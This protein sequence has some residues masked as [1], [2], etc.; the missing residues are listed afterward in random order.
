MPDELIEEEEEFKFP[1]EEAETEE[2][3]IVPFNPLEG[4][5]MVA[6]E[7]YDGVVIAWKF[8]KISEAGEHIDNY[9]M[10]TQ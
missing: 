3:I 5:M 8:V 6:V 4:M 2:E 10:R 7:R 9:L 1:E